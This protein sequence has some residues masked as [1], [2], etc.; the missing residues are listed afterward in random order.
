[1]ITDH[2]ATGCGCACPGHGRALGPELSARRLPDRA[3]SQS[4]PGSS[5]TRVCHRIELTQALGSRRNERDHVR[6]GRDDGRRILT[7]IDNDVPL[8][9]LRVPTPLRSMPAHD[10]KCLVPS[11]LLIRTRT[12][13]VIASR[14][15]RSDHYLPQAGTG[16]VV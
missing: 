9:D 5:R 12:N 7:I 15:H 13:Q 14:H 16:G 11:H 1:V 4:K 3:F 10:E 6:H 8:A 2:R